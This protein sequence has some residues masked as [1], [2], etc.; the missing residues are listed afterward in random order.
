M[1]NLD[2]D[3][4]HIWHPDRYEIFKDAIAQKSR[5]TIQSHLPLDKCD[6][7]D[8]FLFGRF[9]A[10]TG[11]QAQYLVDDWDLN[12]ANVLPPAPSCEYV[13]SVKAP[14]D[15]SGAG[16][17][18]YFGRGVMLDE[19]LGRNNL[20]ESLLL[21]VALPSRVRQKRMHERH[22]CDG[23]NLL[24]PG[25][26]LID[27]EPTDRRKLLNFLARYYE[28]RNR[29][30]PKLIDISAGG[31]CLETEDPYCQRFLGAEESYL[32]F[33]FPNTVGKP[34]FPCVFLGKKVGLF[35]AASAR[36]AGLRIRFSRELIWGNPFGELRWVEVESHGSS[37]MR[38]ILANWD[39]PLIK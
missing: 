36:H 28:Q 23:S 3:T 12:A 11:Q 14:K 6:S 5:V 34:K 17:V 30:R 27:A 32:F 20:P 29:P 18:E 31:V 4:Y 33:F 19:E 8:V 26:M 15:G 2:S 1:N 25:L 35:R 16:I 39:E 21:R 38:E 9:L 13:F 10:I 22:K 37:T 7:A 24:M